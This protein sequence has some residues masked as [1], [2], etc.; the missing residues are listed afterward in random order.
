ML[1]LDMYSQKKTFFFSFLHM[2]CGPC[3]QR[4]K[5]TYRSGPWKKPL[6]LLSTLFQGSS[7]GRMCPDD[8]VVARG[9]QF[10]IHIKL[11]LVGPSSA[12]SNGQTFFFFFNMLIAVPFSYRVIFLHML[13]GTTMP[14]PWRPVILLVVQAFLQY[15]RMKKLV[16]CKKTIGLKGKID[17]SKNIYGK[18]NTSL[19]DIDTTPWFSP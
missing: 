6:K 4:D 3:H 7:S 1:C 9:K 19:L 18:L 2:G 17:N 11:C 5:S 16:L 14:D 10:L 13:F 15:D 8:L 12:N